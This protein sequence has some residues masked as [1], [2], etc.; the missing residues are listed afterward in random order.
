MI[1]STESRNPGSNRLNCRDIFFSGDAVSPAPLE[2]TKIVPIRAANEKSG[3][4]VKVSH[5]L[6]FSFFNL[7]ENFEFSRPI[8]TNTNPLF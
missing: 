6:R 1:D 8:V 5:F 4:H 3:F 7:T 2:I